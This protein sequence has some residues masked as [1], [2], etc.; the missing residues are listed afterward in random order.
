ME[1]GIADQMYKRIDKNKGEDN[2]FW[3]VRISS[4][5]KAIC[6]TSRESPKKRK[7]YW[8]AYDDE[9]EIYWTIF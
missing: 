7:K 1:K 9:P 3:N 6:S 2:A 5:Y 8:L 4:V